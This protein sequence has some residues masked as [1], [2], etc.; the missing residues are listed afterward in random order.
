MAP[1]RKGLNS[2]GSKKGQ[3]KRAAA[4]VIA[5]RIKATRQKPAIAYDSIPAASTSAQKNAA[6][7]ARRIDAVRQ[8]KKAAVSGTATLDSGK[9]LCTSPQADATLEK[10]ATPSEEAVSALKKMKYSRKAKSNSISTSAKPIGKKKE[11]IPHAETPNITGGLR[12]LSRPM[13]TMARVT[14]RL[15]R[16]IKLPIESDDRG[17]PIGKNVANMQ[18]YLNKV[19]KKKKKMEDMIRFVDSDKVSAIGSGTP[20]ARS[21]DLSVMYKNGKPGQIYSIPYNTGQHW[22]LTI[23]NPELETTRYMDPLKRRLDGSEW[24]AIVTD[25]IK[26]YRGLLR[27]QPRKKKAS[28]W[29]PLLGVPIQKDD[30]SCGYYVMRYMKEIVEDNNIDLDK[31]WGTR[32]GLT[33]TAEEIDEIRGEWAEHVLQFPDQ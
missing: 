22:T 33:Y 4:E 27:K 3:K 13:V 12:L 24:S 10:N 19:L 29:K 26:M 18:S 30:V 28:P 9:T 1:A 15:I 11:Q 6:D 17:A 14:K 21:R 5:S 32:A 20:T 23:V 8:L 31:K 2:L 7:I 16:G 25:S